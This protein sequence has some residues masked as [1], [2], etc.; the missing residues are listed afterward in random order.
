MELGHIILLATRKQ[1][2]L[3]LYQFYHIL[4]KYFYLDTKMEI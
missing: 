2:Y 3:K 1:K 4:I